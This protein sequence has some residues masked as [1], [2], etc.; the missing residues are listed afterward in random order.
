MASGEG[1]NGAEARQSARWS[2]GNGDRRQGGVWHAGIVSGRVALRRGKG[3]TVSNG[4]GGTRASRFRGE[5]KGGG[6]DLG[7]QRR[8]QREK[9]VVNDS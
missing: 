9:K 7:G 5:A 8:Y 6:G 1:D 4:K 3:L 2:V